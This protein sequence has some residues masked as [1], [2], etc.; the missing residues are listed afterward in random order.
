MVKS[1]QLPEEEMI[2]VEDKE[3][4]RRLY[5]RRCWSIRKIARELGH[6]RKTVRKALDKFFPYFIIKVILKI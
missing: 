3:E 2:K 4:I 5:F 6:S 1:N